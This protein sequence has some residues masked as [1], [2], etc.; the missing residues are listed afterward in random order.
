M[1]N[2]EEIN[3]EFVK[4]QRKYLKNNSVL[5]FASAVTKNGKS[6]IFCGDTY[7]GKTRNAIKYAKRGWKILGDDYILLKEGYIYK[8]F[9]GPIHIKNTDGIRIP[10]KK[11]PLH[12]FYKIVRFF[13]N[14]KPH[15][16]LNTK[17][18]GFETAEKAKIDK[19]IILG[20]LKGKTIAEKIF[21]NSKKKGCFDLD[22]RKDTQYFLNLMYKIIKK[23]LKRRAK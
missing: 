19:V 7:S 1:V 14:K 10:L 17:E 16:S 8:T 5:I 12:Y 3:T 21:N 15:I 20:N 11:L 9:L 2:K 4:L 13:T 22:K 23:N 18:L 6:I